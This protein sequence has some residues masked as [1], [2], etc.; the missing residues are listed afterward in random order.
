[1]EAIDERFVNTERGC[2]MSLRH[3]SGSSDAYRP[4]IDDADDVIPAFASAGSVPDEHVAWSVLNPICG[5]MVFLPLTV[6]TVRSGSG[7]AEYWKLT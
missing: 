3:R 4:H 7:I 5:A 6:N 2:D 1:M